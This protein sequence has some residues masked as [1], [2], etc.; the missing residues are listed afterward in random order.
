MAAVAVLARGAAGQVCS[1]HWGH[2]IGGGGLDGGVEAM[3]TI[4]PILYVGGKFTTA[5]GVIVNRVASFDG[6][7]WTAL[8][9]GTGSFSHG[10][11]GCC[12]S[13]F[14]FAQFNDGTGPAA[15]LGGDFVDAGGV[16]LESI[17]K[18]QSGTYHPLGTGL[19]YGPGCVDCPPRVYDL[20]VFTPPAGPARLYAAGSFE[21][22]AP[23]TA[24][25]IAGWDGLTW[26]DLA[27]GVASTQPGSPTP[28]WINDIEKFND[29]SGLKLYATGQFTVAGGVAADSIARWTGSAWQAVGGG[30][31]PNGPRPPF[32]YGNA[33]A[34]AALNGQPAAL[35]V[36]GEFQRAGTAAVRNLA[37]WDGTSWHDVGGGVNAQVRA[38]AVFDDGD[39]V[40]LFAG[41]DFSE[42]GVTP[43]GFIAK[44]DGQQWHTLAGGLDG[45]PYA[46]EPYAAAGESALYVGGWF[47]NADGQPSP[48]LAKWIGC[49]NCYADCT[50]DSQLTVADFGCFQTR[51]VL[52]D[53]YADCNA[54]GFLTVADFGC[55]QTRFVTGCP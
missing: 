34:V 44:W 8:G 18:W 47:N 17:G 24:N 4:G 6:A 48:N 26:S 21:F 54:D 28:S 14:A 41:G 46:M 51:F 32:A 23:V 52:Q 39:G 36:G 53:P 31:G 15:H 16:T 27:G 10:I 25:N 45:S 1:P 49:Q 3:K 42:A 29:G 33:V 40:A 37:M 2:N 50:Q 30:L 38:L 43:A 55:F 5:G 12:P 19:A 9:S 7:A 13:V 11:F 35:Y 22:A 20:D